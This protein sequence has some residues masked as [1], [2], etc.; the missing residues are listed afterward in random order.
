[1][2]S[3]NVRRIAEELQDYNTGVKKILDPFEDLYDAWFK[4]RPDDQVQ[5]DRMYKH[6]DRLFK[7]L[8]DHL[9]L[10]DPE[11]EDETRG[12]VLPQFRRVEAMR[13]YQGFRGK[14]KLALFIVHTVFSSWL[15]WLEGGMRNPTPLA[16]GRI[17]ADLLKEFFDEQMPLYTEL[18]A[19]QTRITNY[20]LRRHS[21]DPQPPP[22]SRATT[23]KR[24]RSNNNENISPR[25]R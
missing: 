15:Q 3:N 9:P 23:R 2:S 17:Y 21:A 24:A 25:Q 19:S 4:W 1:M 8:D 18:P 12:R 16:V 14:H 20:P 6:K 22:E 13:E 11:E 5:L 10:L 7:A